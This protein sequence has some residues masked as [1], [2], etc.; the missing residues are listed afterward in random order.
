[1]N[2]EMSKR[3]VLLIDDEPAII[4]TIRLLMMADGFEVQTAWSSREAVAILQNEYFDLVITDFNLPEMKGDELALLVKQ[5]YPDSIV[6]MISGSADILR[7]SGRPLPG[8]DALVGKPF[9]FVE[10]RALVAEQMAGDPVPP[11][12]AKLASR[13]E[14]VQPAAKS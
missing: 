3:R 7:A 4:H 14:L 8:V 10:F 5:R 2:L 9:D 13:R 1:M 11:I 6:I 12:E